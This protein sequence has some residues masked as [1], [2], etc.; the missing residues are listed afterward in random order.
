MKPLALI[1][2]L[3]HRCPL[4]CVYCS[5][6]LVL[7]RKDEEIST[8]QWIEVIDQAAALDIVHV[9]FTGGEPLLRSDLVELI[10]A[11]HDRGLYCN[12]ITSGVGLSRERLRLL[13][14]AGL[15][16]VQLSFQDVDPEAAAMISGTRTQ[17]L[18]M[19]AAEVIRAENIAF[20]VNM[21]VHRQNIGRL[22][23]MIELADRL[24]AQKLEIANAQYNG[25]AFLNKSMLLPTLEQYRQARL[26][27][28][29]AQ[30]NLKGRLRIDFVVPDYLARFPKACM[31]GWGRQLLLVDPSGRVLPCHSA[32]SLPGLEFPNIRERELSWIWNESPLFQKFRGDAWM[33]EICRSCER[34][35][36][37]YGG[38]RCQAFLVT[39]NA[40]AADPVCSRSPDRLLIDGFV[41]QVEHPGNAEDDDSNRWTYRQM[42]SL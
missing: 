23:Q 32:A 41:R 4:R 15:A 1:A 12:L 20:T 18:K 8:R 7:N 13:V 24:G 5:N 38:C 25:W 35:E 40:F 10:A 9:H 21:V 17:Q 29:Q 33:P 6:P 11:A 27:T 2:E 34:K 19:Q 42:T 26:I 36:K 16:H 31:G 3:T 30:A 14:G 22:P 28:E 37:D 39:G